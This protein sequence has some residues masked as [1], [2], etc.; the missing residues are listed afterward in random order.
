M[1]M[2]PFQPEPGHK[3]VKLS[4]RKLRENIRA[5]KKL[6]IIFLNQCFCIPSASSVKYFLYFVL[7][8]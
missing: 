1:E 6:K 8:D 2:M 5:E 4:T 3:Q 7:I